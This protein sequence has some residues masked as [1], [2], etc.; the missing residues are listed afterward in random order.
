[1]AL[2][3]LKG[4]HELV[5]HDI[6]RDAGGLYLAQ[7]LVIVTETNL[8]AAQTISI[9]MTTRAFRLNR[10]NRSPMRFIHPYF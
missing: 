1:M 9:A 3:V 8:R 2:N 4:S 10:L 7:R 6:N 5:M